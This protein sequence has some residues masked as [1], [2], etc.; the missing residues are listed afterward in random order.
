MR[1]LDI[2][3]VSAQFPYPPRSGFTTRVYQL[4][5]QLSS[6]HRVTLLSY[7]EPSDRKGAVALASELRVYALAHEYGPM[8]A[9]RLAQ[10]ASV[11]SPRPFAC[12]VVYSREMQ[13]AIDTLC[14]ERD[15]DIVQL[16]SSALCTFTFPPR[17]QIVLDEHNIEYEL[18]RRMSERERSRVRRAFNHVEY[19]RYRRFERSWWPR[20]GCCVVTSEREAPVVRACAPNTP[21]AV[22][23]NGVDVEQFRPVACDVE[24]HTLVFNGLLTYRP[25]MDA[26]Q[27][28]LDEVWPLVLRRYPHA[29]LVIVGGGPDQELRRLRSRG[30]EVTGHV[31]DIRPYLARAAVVGV[32][33]RIGG[34]TRL[35]VV[36]GL[37]IGKAMV[38]T[39]LGCEG[40]AVRDGE[41]L[42]LGDDAA[43]FAA[44]VLELF[45][46][47]AQRDRI[48][49]AGRRLVEQR[50]SWATA[51]EQLEAAY[52]RLV[53]SAGNTPI[54]GDGR[55]RM[56][57]AC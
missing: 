36:E 44:R 13:Q 14:S 22:V 5:R 41:H 34:G 35:K 7:A 3:I 56:A 49:A 46:N 20:V 39:S 43:S 12:R 8:R 47:P 11:A 50:Y 26:A 32:P 17:V 23:P 21:V 25:N 51:A 18:L 40:L 28:L 57:R 10:V 9:R 38:S 48:G 31:P 6:R 42:L 33:L 1:R 53:T 2:L 37:A 45:A 27:F 55:R 4:A 16:E 24:P 52:D 54:A 15:Y 19:A 30:V 29:R